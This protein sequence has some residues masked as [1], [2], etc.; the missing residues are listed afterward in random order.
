MYSMSFL[1]FQL[2]NN[3]G[4]VIG[5]VIIFTL[6]IILSFGIR[7]GSDVVTIY[8]KQEGVFLPTHIITCILGFFPML[9]LSSEII[10]C[11]THSYIMVYKFRWGVRDVFF[12]HLLSL[13]LPAALQI[14]IAILYRDAYDFNEDAY[15]GGWR[16]ALYHLVIV[17]VLCSMSILIAVIVK[18]VLT[19]LFC[20]LIYITIMLFMD[21]SN[22]W[23]NVIALG[24]MISKE[25]IPSMISWI[26][27]GF[28]FNG[29]ALWIQAGK[30]KALNF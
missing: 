12:C 22:K 1:K 4:V 15:G 30:G 19:S 6:L 3:R 5:Y 23:F 29:I 21:V 26:I 28:L 20:M 17:F 25:A 10:E 27:V 13:L 24:N 18:H 7:F 9:F 2:K 11:K 8:D 14:I 16:N